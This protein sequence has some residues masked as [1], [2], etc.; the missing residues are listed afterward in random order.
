MGKYKVPTLRNVGVT[1]PYMH[2]GVFKDLKTVV[3]FYDKYNNKN[4]TIN[5]ETGKIWDEAEIKNTISLKEL[6]AQEL[7]DKKVE[8]LVAFMKIL[9]DKRY[10]YLLENK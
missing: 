1:A 2:N 7:S 8:A 5:K 9:T 4:R 10:E 3:E 6:K